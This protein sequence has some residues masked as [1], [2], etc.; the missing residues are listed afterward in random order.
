MRT[1]SR[2]RSR[3]IPVPANPSAPSTETADSLSLRLR[4]ETAELHCD[5]ECSL[6]FPQAIANLLKY[7]SCLVS[8]FRLYCPIEASLA[9]FGDWAPAGIQ[10]PERLQTPRLVKDLRALGVDPLRCAPASA[11]WTPAIP[12]FAHAL[13]VFY[14]LEGSTLA[15]Q[16]ILRHLRA[17]LGECIDGADAFFDGH[18]SQSA[19]MWSAARLAIDAY[20]ELHAESCDA[21]IEG[22]ESAFR[23]VGMWML[24]HE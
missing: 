12:D 19:V 24:R 7:R 16:A 6:Q 2:D 13:G 21:V 15:G 17:S 14:V 8:Y 18:G 5:M 3:G 11:D 4:R 23:C 10:L 22:A 9:G 20:G 1:I